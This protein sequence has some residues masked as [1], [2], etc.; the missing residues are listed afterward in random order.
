VNGRARPALSVVPDDADQVV[1]LNQF[2]R[3]HP[4]IAIHAGPGYWQAQIPQPAGEQIITRYRLEELLD[5][6][7]TT[8]AS[9]PGAR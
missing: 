6:L 2:R 9:D 5:K 7:D 1:R 4:G 8:L 3:A